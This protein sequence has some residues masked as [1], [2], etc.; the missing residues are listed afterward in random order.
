MK[1]L[2]FLVLILS[3]M[4]SLVYAHGP[5]RIDV[6]YDKTTQILFVVVKHGVSDPVKHY[7]EKITIN[8]GTNNFFF[9]EFSRQSSKEQE[10]FKI[11]IPNLKQGDDITVTAGCVLFGKKSKTIRIK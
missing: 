9:E 6:A 2:F 4:T 11:R 1:R 8:A 3:C 5:A 10:V 7:I